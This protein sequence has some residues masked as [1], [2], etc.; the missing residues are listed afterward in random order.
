MSDY[1]TQS[2]SVQQST[3]HLMRQTG[4]LDA[5][6]NSALHTPP[7]QTPANNTP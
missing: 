2:R 4:Q 7:A 6:L 1:L 3:I 5:W